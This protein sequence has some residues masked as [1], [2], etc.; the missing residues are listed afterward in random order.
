[1]IQIR[2][3][4]V[5]KALTGGDKFLI[6][7]ID[8]HHRAHN[9]V[10]VK[11][12][13]HEKS[14]TW[15]HL[16]VILDEYIMTRNHVMSSVPMFVKFFIDRIDN[17]SGKMVFNYFTIKFKNGLIHS[18]T[19]PAIIFKDTPDSI[20]GRVWI[21]NGILWQTSDFSRKNI[22]Q[23]LTNMPAVVKHKSHSNSMSYGFDS[24]NTTMTIEDLLDH[25]NYGVKSIILK[26]KNGM[27]PSI[28]LYDNRK[29]FSP[30]GDTLFSEHEFLTWAQENDIQ[31]PTK[32][33]VHTYHLIGG[34]NYFT[35]EEFI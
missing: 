9:N 13:I 17:F 30:Y 10:I 28:Q 20:C 3:S 33:D 32:H 5:S 4:T 29:F 15:E 21:K 35:N 8:P 26:C 7:L 25:G 11:I 24:N 23:N 19:L 16:S 14:T 18:N 22:T 6:T 2:L 31:N 12:D 27:N 1:M 34:K